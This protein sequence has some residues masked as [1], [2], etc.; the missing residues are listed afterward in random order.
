MDFP[1]SAPMS[2]ARLQSCRK[3]ILRRSFL[4]SGSKQLNTTLLQSLNWRREIRHNQT[5][6]SGHVYSD[7]TH[8]I[9][10]IRQLL[11]CVH[12]VDERGPYLLFKKG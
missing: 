2:N 8:G 4:S 1:R 9:V 12:R 3:T 10:I 6:G 11:R 5:Y 7:G